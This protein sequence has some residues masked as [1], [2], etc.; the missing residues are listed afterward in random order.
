MLHQVAL[1]HTQGMKTEIHKTITLNPKTLAAISK[2][3]DS[4]HLSTSQVA[5]VSWFPFLPG[6]LRRWVH[7]LLEIFTHAK[8]ELATVE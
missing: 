2:T 8:A 1:K 6:P 5:T 7:K 3:Y 4:K